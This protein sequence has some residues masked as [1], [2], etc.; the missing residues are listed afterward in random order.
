MAFAEE[1]FVPDNFFNDDSTLATYKLDGD[2]GDDSGN[3]NNGIASNVTYAAGKFD[4]AAVFNGS[5]SYVNLNSSVI[6]ANSSFSIS[7][8]VKFD[9][10]ATTSGDR[11]IHIGN[12]DAASGISIFVINS[13]LYLRIV[14]SNGNPQDI[15]Y[16]PSNNVW[17]NL[18]I[19][20]DNSTK[21][22][23]G[24]VDNVLINTLTITGFT[25]LG[26]YG[27]IGSRIGSGGA[28]QF[29]DGSIDQVRIFDRALTSGEVTQLYN[30]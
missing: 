21:Q 22:F 5:S 2:A 29:L 6:S 11:S 1:V 4:D 20:Y 30:E 23:K 24:Y 28:N 8:W 10:V 17:Y 19:T 25:P 18:V 3:G 9:N 12:S 27:S 16:S 13:T 14:D 26:N 15:T 7:H